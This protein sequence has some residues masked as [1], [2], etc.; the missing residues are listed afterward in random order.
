MQRTITGPQKLYAGFLGNPE[1]PMQQQQATLEKEFWV[2]LRTI[3][4]LHHGNLVALLGYCI[5][6]HELFLIYDLMFNGSLDQ[7]LHE[8]N[9]GVA[10]ATFLDWK[11]RIRVAINVA[12]GLEYLH[13][14]A[15]PTLV[16]RD[17]KSSNILFDDDICKRRS[18][19]SVLVKLS[20]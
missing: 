15:H 11:A 14:H 18:R 3:T 20:F 7:H 12:Q 17:I 2:E 10:A 9:S 4:H 16:H 19:T 13:C 5:E 1:M 8:C 6:G